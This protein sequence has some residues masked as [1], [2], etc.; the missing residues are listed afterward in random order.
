MRCEVRVLLNT[1]EFVCV[2]HMIHEGDQMLKSPC[3]A[4][5][6]DIKSLLTNTG[7]G[8]IREVAAVLTAFTN[9]TDVAAFPDKLKVFYS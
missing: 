2:V 6:V 8:K 1:A 3:L 4:I 9:G 7:K 5:Q